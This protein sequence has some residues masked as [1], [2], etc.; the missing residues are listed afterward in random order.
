MT[1]DNWECVREVKYN[2]VHVGSSE[3]VS[4][5]PRFASLGTLSEKKKRQGRAVLPLH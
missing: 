4:E 2:F 3:F 1:C 5:V